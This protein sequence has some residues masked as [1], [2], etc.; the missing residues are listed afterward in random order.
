MPRRRKSELR[1]PSPEPEITCYCPTINNILNRNDLDYAEKLFLIRNHIYFSHTSPDGRVHMDYCALE[2]HM[3][4]ML[5]YM[6]Q[7]MLNHPP[8]EDE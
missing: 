3:G 4:N 1:E 6:I 2:Y 7:H 5:D 8:E